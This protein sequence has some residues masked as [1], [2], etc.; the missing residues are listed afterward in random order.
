MKKDTKKDLWKA[1]ANLQKTIDSRKSKESIDEAMKKLD[2]IKGKVAEEEKEE[3]VDI[4]L[5]VSLGVYGGACDGPIG[6]IGGV[7]VGFVADYA[8]TKSE[9]VKTLLEGFVALVHKINQDSK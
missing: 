3:D 6:A 4:P 8:A 1:M 7:A 2:E 9:V 5:C